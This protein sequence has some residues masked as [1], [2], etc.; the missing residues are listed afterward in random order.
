MTKS[1]AKVILDF[2]NQRWLGYEKDKHKF[3]LL[4][5]DL[6]NLQEIAEVKENG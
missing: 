4:N 1:E 2:L 5:D 6:K 3:Y